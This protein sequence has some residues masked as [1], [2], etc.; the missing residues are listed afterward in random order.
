M[1][2]YRNLDYSRVLEMCVHYQYYTR[3]DI[4]SYNNMLN[5]CK[6]KSDATDSVII[7]IAKDIY[8]HTDIQKIMHEYGCDEKEVLANIVFNLCNDCCFTQVE[9]ED[10]DV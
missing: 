2:I 1:R 8:N 4:S 3:G 9:A 10:G 5:M 6:L 7:S